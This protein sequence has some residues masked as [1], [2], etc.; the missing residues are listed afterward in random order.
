MAEL[1][2]EDI[3][4]IMTYINGSLSEAEALLFEER[5][6]KDVLFRTEVAAYEEAKLAAFV[7]GQSRIKAILKDEAEKYQEE[8]SAVKQKQAKIIP[9]RAWI[10][11]KWTPMERGVAAAF[12]IGV[13]LW[14]INYFQKPKRDTSQ[15]F[16]ANFNASFEGIPITRYRGKDDLKIDSFFRQRHDSATLQLA[17]N[18]LDAY[19]QKNYNA[20][21]EALNKIQALD[22]T[23]SLCK[24]TA[25]LASDKAQ[26]AQTILTALTQNGK[27][28]TQPFAEWYLALAYLKQGNLTTCHIWLE[29]IIAMPNHPYK[30]E[31]HRLTTQLSK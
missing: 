26:E 21:I 19:A 10:L 3:Q 30:Q 18:A 4:L 29:K 15:L 8:N 27:G 5:H 24:A 14:A 20:S 17:I 22:D 7:G 9:F 16:V 11:S 12:L 13:C 23:L 31:A 28:Y 2:E 25:L 1:N 6:Q